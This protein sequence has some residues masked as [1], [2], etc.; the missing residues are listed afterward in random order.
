MSLPPLGRPPPP[1]R[2][3]PLWCIFFALPAKN[4]PLPAELK[5]RKI[6]V[7]IFYQ[8]FGN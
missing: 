2:K 6:T 4:G 7:L 8:L 1:P 5:L 3:V